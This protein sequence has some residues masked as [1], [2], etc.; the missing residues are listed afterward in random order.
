[1]R[2]LTQQAIIFAILLLIRQGGCLA[3]EPE[4]KTAESVPVKYYLS[5]PDG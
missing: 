4:L 5:L 2:R 3:S 1:M